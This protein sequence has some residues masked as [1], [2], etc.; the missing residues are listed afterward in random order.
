MGTNRREHQ[1]Q[2]ILEDF[3]GDEWTQPIIP[4]NC[5]VPVVTQQPFLPGED[6]LGSLL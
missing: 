1:D 2:D 5:L 3:P 6:T 4:V